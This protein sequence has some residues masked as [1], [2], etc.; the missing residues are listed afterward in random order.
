MFHAVERVGVES[1]P[2]L[3]GLSL[4]SQLVWSEEDALWKVVDGDE[5]LRTYPYAALR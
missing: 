5:V 3:M 2:A 4:A 1:E